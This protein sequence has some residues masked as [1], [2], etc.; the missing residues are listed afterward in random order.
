MGRDLSE[1]CPVLM[2]ENTGTEKAPE[3]RVYFKTLKKGQIPKFSDGKA[4]TLEDM[5]YQNMQSVDNNE[6]IV[7]LFSEAS[8]LLQNEVKDLFTAP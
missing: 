6:D 1:R 3:Y 8:R 7:P 2:C 5:A 4:I